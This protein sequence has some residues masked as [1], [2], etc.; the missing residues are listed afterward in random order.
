MAGHSE[1]NALNVLKETK[2]LLGWVDGL[3]CAAS[4]QMQ[5]VIL[6]ISA[7]PKDHN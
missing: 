7:V 6:G 4:L 5:G 1:D 2:L 3:D